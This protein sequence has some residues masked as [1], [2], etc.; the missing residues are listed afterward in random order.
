MQYL[1][2]HFLDEHDIDLSYDRVAVQR[3][4]DAAEEAKIKLSTIHKTRVHIPFITQSQEEQTP[5][6]LEVP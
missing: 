5:I 3:I 4:R 6:D 2:E 1:L